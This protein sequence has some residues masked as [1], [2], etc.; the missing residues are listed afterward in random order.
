M[1]ISI[2]DTLL[3]RKVDKY[4]RHGIEATDERLT[5]SELRFKHALARDEDVALAVEEARHREGEFFGWEDEI[6]AESANGT[7]SVQ[8]SSGNRSFSW[9]F[10]D[11]EGFEVRTWMPMHAP[12]QCTR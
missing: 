10:D 11:Q 4:S 6:D 9:S 1:G 7:R 2:R 8:Q 12:L 5:A 3:L